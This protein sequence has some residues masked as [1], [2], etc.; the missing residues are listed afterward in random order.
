MQDLDTFLLSLSLKQQKSSDVSF[1]IPACKRDKS[2]AA[3]LKVGYAGWGTGQGVGS[4]HLALV[5]ASTTLREAPGCWGPQLEH[6]SEGLAFSVVSSNVANRASI[7]KPDPPRCQKPNA[8]LCRYHGSTHKGCGSEGSTWWTQRPTWAESTPRRPLGPHVLCLPVTRLHPVIPPRIGGCCLNATSPRMSP[9]LAHPAIMV[10]VS[11]ALH[12][13]CLASP[14][15]AANCWVCPSPF[16]C[17]NSKSRP[18]SAAGAVCF[19]NCRDK[20]KSRWSQQSTSLSLGERG[21]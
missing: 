3:W 6:P 10:A 17:S 18:P 16:P 19:N 12:P 20:K 21:I 14:L 5:A 15:S 1:R 7:R 9:R 4:P 11:L 13:A 2:R 8:G